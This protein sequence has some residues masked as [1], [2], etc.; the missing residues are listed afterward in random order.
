[1]EKQEKRGSGLVWPMIL[2]GAGIVLLL[3][4]LGLLA[5]DVWETIF[6]LWPILLIAIGL[7]IL[8]GRRSAWASLLVVAGVLLALAGSVWLLSRGSGTFSSGEGL[9]TLEISE[10]LQGATSAEVEIGLGAGVLRLGALSEADKLIEGTIAVERGEKVISARQGSGDATRYT[11]RTEGTVRA[12]SWFGQRGRAL[13]GRTWELRLNRDVPLRLSVSTGAGQ[14]FLNL[15]R[16]NLTYLE[17]DTGVGQATLTLPE[18][19]RFR[20]QVNA[21]VGQVII[22]L[23]EGLAARI[24]VDAGIGGVEVRGDYRR[25]DDTYVS[26]NYDT[27]ANRVDLEVDG[28][29]GQIR[30]EAYKGE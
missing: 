26:P 10:P 30:I 7:D 27:A 4:N 12:F 13:E 8:I 29:V 9:R 20:A 2:I 28:G 24:R 15:E 18:R 25:Q 1:M 21:G 23:P 19:G 3:N 11:L 5:W 16:L 17:V 6:R 22:R 14:A